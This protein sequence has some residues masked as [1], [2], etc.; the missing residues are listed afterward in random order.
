M[1]EVTTPSRKS[2]WYCRTQKERMKW[3]IAKYDAA[4]IGFYLQAAVANGLAFYI[5]DATPTVGTLNDW[6]Y[7][8]G[9]EPVPGKDYDEAVELFRNKLRSIRRR[10]LDAAEAGCAGSPYQPDEDARRVA[11]AQQA[12]R[13]LADL[14]PDMWL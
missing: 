4:N 11:G 14:L 6:G 12:W 13:E 9:Y 1:L 5:P 7:Y 10:L 8:V 2:E 3:G